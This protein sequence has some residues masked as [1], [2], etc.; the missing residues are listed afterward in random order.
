MLFAPATNQLY[1]M[2]RRFTSI[3]RLSP[4]RLLAYELLLLLSITGPLAFSQATD[5]PW[6]SATPSELQA[7]L[8]ARAPV[9]QE[10]IETEMRSASGV[11]NGHGQ[12]FAG[13]V[14]IT[15]GYSA[16]GKYSHYLI[17][18]VPVQIG[19]ISLPPGEYVFGWD[20][21]EDVL[22]VH[23]YDAATGT[24]RGSSPAT[25]HHRHF[26][27]YLGIVRPVRLHRVA[28]D[29]RGPRPSFLCLQRQSVIDW[30]VQQE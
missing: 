20:R 14:L 18:Q 26:L 16:D 22:N 17:A 5:T 8:P 4:T 25:R 2:R 1:S 23:F 15:A 9:Q 12:F 3:A 24:P 28:V 30:H 19:D 7:L 10:H 29:A 27:E 21:G 6:R 13:V 11:T